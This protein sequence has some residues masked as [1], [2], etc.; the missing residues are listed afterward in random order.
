MRLSARDV[1]RIA[2]KRAA[3]PLGLVVVD[4]EPQDAGSRHE[5]GAGHGEQIARR[6][7][8]LA[9]S[10][11]GKHHHFHL[12]LHSVQDGYRAPHAGERLRLHRQR[13]KGKENQPEEETSKPPHVALSINPVARR[14]RNKVQ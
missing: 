11:I 8:L 1:D 3:P 7:R 13:R 9:E 5:L 14:K 4:L 6:Y 2:S 12:S 10:A